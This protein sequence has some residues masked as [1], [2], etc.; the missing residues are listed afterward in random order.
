M[1]TSTP[2]LS[3]LLITTKIPLCCCATAA[4]VQHGGLENSIFKNLVT[5]VGYQGDDAIS[6]NIIYLGRAVILGP[7]IEAIKIEEPICHIATTPSK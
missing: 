7:L 3:S 1:F 2:P 6:V 4:S 5:H